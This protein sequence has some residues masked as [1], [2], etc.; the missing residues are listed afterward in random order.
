MF[1]SVKAQIY[2]VTLVYFLVIDSIAK[3]PSGVSD[4]NLMWTASYFYCT[5]IEGSYNYTEEIENSTDIY[6]EMRY[7]LGKHCRMSFQLP[8]TVRRRSRL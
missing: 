4:G 1:F 2:A 8:N 3:I 6:S 5:N 7:T